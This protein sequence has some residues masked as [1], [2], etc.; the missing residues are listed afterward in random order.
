MGVLRGHQADYN[1]VPGHTLILG[2]KTCW[3]SYSAMLVR[4]IQQ[5]RAIRCAEDDININ[6][7]Y[8]L[9]LNDWMLIPKVNR[10]LKPFAD[11][12]LDAEH[13]YTC[14]SDTIPFIKKIFY[15]LNAINEFGIN[16]T[17]KKEMIVQLKRYFRGLNP[18]VHFVDGE[19]SEVHALATLLDPRYKKNGFM[20]KAKAEEAKGK[21]VSVASNIFKRSLAEG[22]FKLT[23][24]PLQKVAGMQF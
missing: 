24:I 9:T 17:I 21:L 2:E 3:S 19:T 15:E 22:S 1:G 13:E 23:P 11:A 16:N 6:R 5:K 14:I 7:E 10:L 20:D 8:Q 18:R 4:L 12:T